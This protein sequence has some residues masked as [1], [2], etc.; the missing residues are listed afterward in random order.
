MCSIGAAVFV[1]V[2]VI[3]AKQLAVLRFRA[4]LMVF[5]LVI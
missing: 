4:P 2:D 3:V 5:S 1:A